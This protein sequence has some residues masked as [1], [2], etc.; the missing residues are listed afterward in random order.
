[1]NLSNLSQDIH[2]KYQKGEPELAGSY[3]FSRPH[4]KIKEDDF[5]LDIKNVACYR[6]QNGQTIWINPYENADENSVDLFLEGSVLG[7]LLHQRGILPFHGSSFLYKEKGIMICGHSGVG[8]R[9]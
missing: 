1:M 8:S 5:F 3:I 9:P 6:V 2:I 4:F 7:A